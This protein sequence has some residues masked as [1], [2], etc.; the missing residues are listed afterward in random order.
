MKTETSQPITL[1]ENI[2]MSKMLVKDIK[3]LS[4]EDL[5]TKMK[6]NQKIAEYVKAMYE[7]IKFDKQ[8]LCAIESFDGLQYK[9]LDYSSLTDEEKEY[10][11]NHIY[12][13]TGLYGLV[14]PKDSIYQH[15]LDFNMKFS[16]YKFWG[17]ILYRQLP[18]GEVIL[19]VSSN[20]FMKS[21]QPYAKSNY[22]KVFFKEKKGDK[23]ISK[24]TE[25]K[26]M[27]GLFVRW[28]CKNRIE[29]INQLFEYNEHG[30][31]LSFDEKNMELVY[32]K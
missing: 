26:M 18:K 16:L 19:D 13:Y 21:V 23:L 20:E 1:P 29:N 9:R 14:K 32:V 30:Y 25:S 6:I 10:L 8:G 17:D 31:S 7:N 4:I 5:Q 24:A 22:Y 15:R 12:I 11:D 2:E 27:R 3:E 28:M